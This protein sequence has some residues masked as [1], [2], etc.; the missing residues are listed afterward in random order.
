MIKT[1]TL[2]VIIGIVLI[3]TFY[4]FFQTNS[5]YQ[6]SFKARF[7][8]S[9]GNY[10]MSKELSLMAL[11]LDMYNKMAISTHTNSANAL[12]IQHYITQGDEYLNKI[13]TISKNNATDADNERIRI[14]CD[15]MIDDYLNIINLH[16]SDKNLKQKAKNMQENFKILKN[17]LFKE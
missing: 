9:I 3:L 15:I 13:R 2:T 11:N 10:Q 16:T 1:K 5:S 7:Y 8:E 14:M 17:E 6:L 4:I 12:K